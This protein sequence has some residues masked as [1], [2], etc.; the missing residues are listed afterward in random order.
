VPPTPGLHNHPAGGLA[1]LK[2]RNDQAVL[3]VYGE[4]VFAH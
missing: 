3:R 1:G 4:P 2:R